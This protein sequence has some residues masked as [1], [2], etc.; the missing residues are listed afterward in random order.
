M[1]TIPVIQLDGVGIRRS[2][3]DV[4]LIEDVDWTVMAGDW[5][6]ITGAHGSG[7]SALLLALAGLVPTAGGTLTAFGEPVLSGAPK[8]PGWIPRVGLVFEGGGRLLRDLR[9]AEN[10]AL[11]TGY[12]HNCSLPEAVDRVWP[13]LE[14]LDLERLADAPAGRVGRAWAQRIALARALSLGPEILLLDNPTAGMDPAHTVWWQGFLLR[15]CQGHP[16]LQGR[17]M[18]L[19]ETTDNP[20]AAMNSLPRRAHLE[21]GRLIVPGPRTDPV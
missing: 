5:W 8:P 6:E 14:A 18:T 19:I 11:P 20:R 16:L 15:L 3:G 21:N 2:D 12:H 7:K 1:N 13:W 10:I 4:P 9:V 17:P